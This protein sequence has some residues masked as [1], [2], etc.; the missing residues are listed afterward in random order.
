MTVRISD[1]GRSFD[2]LAA[3]DPNLTTALE[4][5]SIGGLGIYLARKVVDRIHY[6]R[7]GGKNILTLNKQ[8]S[9]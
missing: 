1:T 9:L 8:L 6:E 5:R 3:P 2:P 4:E 7:R